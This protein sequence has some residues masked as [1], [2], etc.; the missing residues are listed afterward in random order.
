[1]TRA[2]VPSWQVWTA[3]WLVYV[4]WGSTY[5]AIA[6]VVDTVPPLVGMG[7]R[8]AAAAS[9]LVAYIAVRRGTGGAR[10]HV[11]VG[12]LAGGWAIGAWLGGPTREHEDLEISILRRDQ[13]LLR[14]HLPGWALGHADLGIGHMKYTEWFLLDRDSRSGSE[15]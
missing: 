5:L 8:F 10:R 13:T 1:M 9:L 3:L 15:A 2:S 11:A 6:Y 12:W 4:V 7:L 14:R